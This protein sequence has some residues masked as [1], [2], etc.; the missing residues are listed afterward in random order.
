MPVLID[1]PSAV[2]DREAVAWR[3]L[4]GVE[5]ARRLG[6]VPAT[7]LP[8]QA[9]SDRLRTMAPTLLGAV[10][11]TFLLQMATIYV[12]ALNP[13][14]DTQPL[15]ARELVFCLALALMVFIVVE[16]EKLLVRR[17]CLYSAP[18]AHTGPN[19]DSISAR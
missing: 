5:V 10:A 15:T 11:L 1:S 17:G 2:A 6:V 4:A 9:A 7:G 18:P 3:E 8:A 12:P 14:F 16:I 19:T 13:V